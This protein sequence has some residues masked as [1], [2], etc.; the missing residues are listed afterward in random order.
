MT[1]PAKIIPREPI[2]DGSIL[3]RNYDLLYDHVEK[4]ILGM[5]DDQRSGREC[6][7]EIFAAE[8]RWLDFVQQHGKDPIQVTFNEI[9][10]RQDGEGFSTLCD[11]Y[12]ELGDAELRRLCLEA[13]S[14]H[15][16]NAIVPRENPSI[17][18]GQE[19]TAWVSEKKI[20]IVANWLV[21]EGRNVPYALCTIYRKNPRYSREDEN[22]REKFRL[23][24]S[25]L[26]NNQKKIIICLHDPE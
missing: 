3:F 13:K 2:Q 24:E 17:A 15:Q 23:N 4:H 20:V 11:L 5:D 1:K 19:I 12:E 9:V 26:P 16:H 14:G 21:R 25:N 7:R 22:K 10:A 18:D 8:P 6:W